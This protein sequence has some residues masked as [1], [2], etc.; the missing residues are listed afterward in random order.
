MQKSS[1]DPS[2]FE[3]P[4]KT[5]TQI[6]PQTTGTS[7]ASEYTSRVVADLKIQFDEVQHLRRDLG[8][9]KQ[10]Y[11]DFM[12]STKESL[13]SLRSQTTAVKQLANTKIGGARAYIDTG[14]QQLDLRSQTVLTEVE[15]L[16]DI[17]EAVRDDVTKRQITPKPQYLKSVKQEIDSCAT[18][19]ESL[20]QYI[21]TV[22]PMWKKTWE[23]EL[24]NIVEE[25]GFLMHQEEFLADLLDDHKAL[26]EVFGHV[27]KVIS[28]RNSGSRNRTGAT[29]RP[30]PPEEGHGGLNSVLREIRGGGVVDSSKILR[31]I[32]ENQKNRKKELA[33][34]TDEM[35]AEL[36][37][38]VG[39]K[40]LR[41]TGGTE[42]T[43]RVRQR[44][45]DLSLKAMFNNQGSI[46]PSPSGLPMVNSTSLSF[47]A[48]RDLPPSPSP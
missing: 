1:K 2:A 31:T 23:E 48:A 36:S 26:A 12:K 45:N 24:Q 33:S 4:S 6:L 7:V 9:M 22:K 27:E 38:F 43:E 34:R 29:Y 5:P 32:E 37:E 3:T 35:H 46:S 8:V 44:K 40:K 25:Q 41:M 18:E 28:L 14:K 11:T 17:A 30:P 20:R 10:L 21:N 15:K 47:A 42:E 16:Q 19:L 39:A 13:G